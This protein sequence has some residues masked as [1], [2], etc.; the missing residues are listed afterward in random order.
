[1]S[2]A[3]STAQHRSRLPKT[4]QL[5]AKA[6]SKGQQ[7]R[8]DD[9]LDAMFFIRVAF[10]AVLGLVWGVVGAQGLLAFLT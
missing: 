4:V 2:G 5:L 10:A 3:A 8:E 1:M 7:W 6:A 9:A